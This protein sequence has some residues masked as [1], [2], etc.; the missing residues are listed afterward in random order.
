MNLTNEPFSHIFSGVY[1]HTFQFLTV[2]IKLVQCEKIL[3]EVKELRELK[4]NFPRK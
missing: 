1:T 3:Y 4:F 2:L